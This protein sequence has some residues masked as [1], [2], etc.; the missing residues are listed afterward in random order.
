MKEYV[1]RRIRE[2]MEMGTAVY[3]NGAARPLDYRI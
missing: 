3:E 1:A 2:L